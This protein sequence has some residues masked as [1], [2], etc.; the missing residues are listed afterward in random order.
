MGS[1]PLVTRDLCALLHGTE[2][3]SQDK[4]W[5]ISAIIKFIIY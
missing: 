1:K 5:F 2:N 3:D 4:L